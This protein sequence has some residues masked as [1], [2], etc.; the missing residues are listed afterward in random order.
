MLAKRC[1]AESATWKPIMG[2]PSLRKDRL[3][4][5]DFADQMSFER[6]ANSGNTAIAKYLQRSTCSSYHV[7]KVAKAL[8]QQRHRTSDQHS[9]MVGYKM[10]QTY[11]V[12]H[13]T[14]E[15]PCNVEFLIYSFT[16]LIPISRLYFIAKT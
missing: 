8:R 2:H 3:R 15:P 7:L 16:L 6:P 12:H 13:K 9:I 10:L 1:A 4:L 11:V 5:L 14:P